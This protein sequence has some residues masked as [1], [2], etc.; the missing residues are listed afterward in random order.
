MQGEIQPT[1]SETRKLRRP[2][3]LVAGATGYLGGFVVQELRRRGAFIRGLVRDPVRAGRLSD[4]ADEIVSGEVTDPKTLRSVCD[5]MDAVF[6]SVGIT[7]QKDGLRYLDVDYQGNRNLLDAALAANIP[8]FVY[9]A[10]LGAESMP[11]VKLIQAKERFVRELQAAELKSVIIRPSGFFSDL[12]EFLKMAERGRVYLFGR[13][14]E[15]RMNPIH[16]ADLAVVC[17][18]AL[19]DQ[20]DVDDSNAAFVEIGGPEVLSHDDIAR[21][22]FA[23]LGREPRITYLPIWLARSGAKLARWLLPQSLGGPID[24][25]LHALTANA[26]GKQTG[27]Q[28]V[29]NFF[30]EAVQS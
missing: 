3:I 18:Q 10:S 12:L 13:P 14:G 26:V 17:A 11:D 7:R 24:F 25:L 19:V 23:A 4:F 29:A 5:G 15:I 27:E 1:T 2:R 22:A 30:R 8:R 6:S 21:H 28:T 9:V 16:G 20:N